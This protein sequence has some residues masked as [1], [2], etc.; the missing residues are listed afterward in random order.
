[1]RSRKIK[2][3]YSS[4][5]CTCLLH[6]VI[7]RSQNKITDIFMILAWA[8]SFNYGQI[9]PGQ[10]NY[11]SF[12]IKSSISSKSWYIGKN[13]PQTGYPRQGKSWKIMWIPYQ[14]KMCA[15][16]CSKYL[17]HAVQK[18]LK[19]RLFGANTFLLPTYLFLIKIKMKFFLGFIDHFQRNIGCLFK[20]RFLQGICF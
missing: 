19:I 18:T 5:L 12:W 16:P 13:Y 6:R 17:P 20:Y 4:S 1:M 10:Y 11:I 8:S 9:P 2:K 3:L 14:K 7:L 15:L